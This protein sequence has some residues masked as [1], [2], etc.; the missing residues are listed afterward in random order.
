M[1][2]GSRMGHYHRVVHA[3]IVYIL[4]Q[5]TKSINANSVNAGPASHHV[6]NGK[7]RKTKQ[8]KIELTREE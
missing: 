6:V 7:R 1:T 2:F 4:F 3:V 5:G 8:Q